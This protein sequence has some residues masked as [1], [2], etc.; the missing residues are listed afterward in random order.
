ME[1]VEIGKNLDVDAVALVAFQDVRVE[2]SA[3]ALEKVIRAY[4]MY[5]EALRRGEQ[6]YGVTTGLGEL[7]KHRAETSGEL[8]LFEHAVGVGA[9]APREWVR[10]TMLIRAHQLALGYSGVRSEVIMTLVQLINSGITPIVPIFG[11]VGASGDLA[12]LAHIALAVMG[13]GRVEY[14]G[15]VMTA[16]EAMMKEGLKPLQLN[17]RESLA[18]INGTSFSTAILALALDKA[19]K[20]INKYL[21]HIPLY[22]YATGAN[23]KALAPDTQVKLHPGMKAVANAIKCEK[24]EKRLNDP[25]SIRCLPQILGALQD[26]LHWVRQITENEINSP[27][28]NPIFTIKGPVPTCHFHGVYIA[29]AADTLAIA[30]AMWANL[31]ER[32]IAQLLRSEITGKP[33]FLTHES[34]SVG[35]MIYHY[36]SAAL[37]AYIRALS[38]PYSIHNI[39]TSGFQEDINSMSL[40]AVVR[41]HEI[42]EKLTHIMSI[43]AVVT[44]DAVDC[45]TCPPTIKEIYQ[46][47]AN[48]IKDAKIPSDRVRLASALW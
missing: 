4:E 42:L 5:L 2:I 20:L 44:H 31:L 7:V 43:H 16:R 45:A 3:S 15:E 18:L 38:T 10:A 24:N 33:D 14:R 39:P 28:D 21:E 19:T 32:Q 30:L 47:V 11:S 12:P 48:L 13:E 26:T 46:K 17:S 29:L 8:I 35:D 22:L 37:A 6:I 36:T 9:K 25:Y 1:I 40:N 41:L 34:G 23:W 27:S